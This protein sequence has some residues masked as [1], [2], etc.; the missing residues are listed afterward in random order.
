MC[1]HFGTQ[2][3]KTVAA[4]VFK[5]QQTRF[6]PL[7]AQASFGTSRRA[8]E[9]HVDSIG[10]LHFSHFLF[11]VPCV[12]SLSFILGVAGPRAVR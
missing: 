12:S 1:F 2:K 3:S 11:I 5:K 8:N 4:L 10:L 6:V 9:L 7:K